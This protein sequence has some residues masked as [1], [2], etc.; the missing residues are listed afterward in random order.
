VRMRKMCEEIAE[1]RYIIPAAGIDVDYSLVFFLTLCME[2]SKAGGREREL[3]IFF[4][5]SQ[6]MPIPCARCVC[7]QDLLSTCI[8]LC[9][10]TQS[11]LCPGVIPRWLC[12]LL[13]LLEMWEGTATMVKWASYPKK[14]F[15]CGCVNYT[16]NLTNNRVKERSHLYFCGFV[17]NS[18]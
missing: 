7:D 9:H 3:F 15:C 5:F 1:G 2:V 6:E 14:V 13:L 18:L 11:K 17:T 10:L 8:N 12:P 16:L 4:V